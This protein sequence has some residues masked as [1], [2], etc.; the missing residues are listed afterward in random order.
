M[1]LFDVIAFTFTLALIGGFIYGVIYVVN[2]FNQ[3]VESTKANLKSRG[4]DI[5]A[6]GMSVKTDKYVDRQDYIDA[7]QRKIINV[8][9][10][11]SFKKGGGA[12][13]PGS[14]DA[15]SEESRRRRNIF[16]RK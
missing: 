16:H 8:M 6:N 5:S 1:A 12:V 14:S 9:E 7:T 10:A 11:S 4:M 2:L 15:A 13:S 3:S